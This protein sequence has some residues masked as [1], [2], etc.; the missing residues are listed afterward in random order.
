MED[1]RTSFTRA[2]GFFTMGR[3]GLRWWAQGLKFFQLLWPKYAVGFLI[4]EVAGVSLSAWFFDVFQRDLVYQIAA[5][6]FFLRGVGCTNSS[7]SASSP[8][9]AIPGQFQPPG[10]PCGVDTYVEEQHLHPSDPA[11]GPEKLGTCHIPAL[12]PWYCLRP[13]LFALTRR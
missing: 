9:Y 2:C 13:P 4:G 1:N 10:P 8:F 7:V 6:G 12:E 11:P 3:G 5:L